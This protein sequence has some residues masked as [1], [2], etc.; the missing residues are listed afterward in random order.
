M[1]H[2]VTETLGNGDGPLSRVQALA[3]MAN[4]L[5]GLVLVGL[6]LRHKLPLSDLRAILPDLDLPWVQSQLSRVMTDPS[7]SRWYFENIDRFDDLFLRS[8]EGATGK[9][10]LGSQNS[11]GIDSAGG[12]DRRFAVPCMP[13]VKRSLDHWFRRGSHEKKVSGPSSLPPDSNT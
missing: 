12:S 10:V 1:H 6:C 3:S 5:P 2:S 11:Q 4:Q 13:V 7:I 9:T 8:L